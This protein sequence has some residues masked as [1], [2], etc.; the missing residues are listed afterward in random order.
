MEPSTRFHHTIPGP[1][2][3][4]RRLTSGFGGMWN[5]PLTT[6]RNKAFSRASRHASSEFSNAS[7]GSAGRQGSL[8]MNKKNEKM[9]R[10][11]TTSFLPVPTKVRSCPRI[12]RSPS[13][14]QIADRVKK[15]AARPPPVIPPKP[16]LKHAKAVSETRIPSTAP[17]K[18][19]S[20]PS[21]LPRS[22][23]HPNLGVVTGGRRA[24]EYSRRNSA[25]WPLLEDERPL[26]R[27]PLL[28]SPMLRTPTSEEE[29]FKATSS[30]L[31]ENTMVGNHGLQVASD[32]LWNALNSP[33]RHAWSDKENLSSSHGLMKS[34]PP[35]RSPRAPIQHHQLL[36]PLRPATPPSNGMFQSFTDVSVSIADTNVSPTRNVFSNRGSLLRSP[37]LEVSSETLPN[38]F[39]VDEAKKTEYWCGRFTSLNDKFLNEAFDVSAR[40]TEEDDVDSSRDSSLT[41]PKPSH[42]SSPDPDLLR[43][44][45][46]FRALD[47][48]CITDEARRSLMLF[49]NMYAIRM[50]MPDLKVE[51]PVSPKPE[52][53]E[54]LSSS[55]GSAGGGGMMSAGFRKMSLMGMLRRRKSSGKS[56]LSLRD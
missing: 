39:V 7:T 4:G 2:S 55:L 43:A 19:F 56:I 24:S 47:E 25:R 32:P 22:T 35:L 13:A 6:I 16:P 11:K 26:L 52:E 30:P 9:V 5:K 23:T 37:P 46:V 21:Y 44:Q 28:E 8:K 1:S 17:R 15:P 40:P 29:W 50:K 10:S 3:S 14:M 12:Y 34:S 48:S 38:I 36:Q 45:K 41:I 53:K 49:R 51:I 18:S 42:P 31:S 27:S 33:R 20:R 54:V